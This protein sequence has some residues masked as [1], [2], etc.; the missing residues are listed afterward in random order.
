MTGRSRRSRS[1]APPDEKA[2]ADKRAGFRSLD[3]LRLCA[4]AFVSLRDAAEVG[5]ALKPEAFEISPTRPESFG[6]IH[7][8]YT[9]TAVAA[10][11]VAIGDSIDQAHDPS[12]G[13]G[14]LIHAF[15]RS[16]STG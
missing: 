1:L 14:R 16:R 3:D 6:L 11:A 2:P 10:V 7:E 8:Y 5:L 15:G 9:P 4:L 12:V 13:I